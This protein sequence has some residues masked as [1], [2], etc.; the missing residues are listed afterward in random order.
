MFFLGSLNYNYFWRELLPSCSCWF[1][2]CLWRWTS[3]RHGLLFFFFKTK[4]NCL[5][6]L[7]PCKQRP[8]HCNASENYFDWCWKSVWESALYVWK[9]S[10][11]G[12][13]SLSWRTTVLFISWITLNLCGTFLGLIF[14]SR[15][16]RAAELLTLNPYPC[17]HGHKIRPI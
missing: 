12:R 6:N 16:V 7:K 14:Q 3:G 5:K 8:E 11:E 13:L 10:Q 15:S 17:L 9:V 2:G 4:P 1:M